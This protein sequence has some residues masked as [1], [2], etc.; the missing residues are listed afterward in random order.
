MSAIVLS[1][2]QEKVEPVVQLKPDG[3]VFQ[4]NVSGMLERGQMYGS[5]GGVA[6]FIASAIM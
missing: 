5:G 3:P 1:P 6:T 4:L 2:W